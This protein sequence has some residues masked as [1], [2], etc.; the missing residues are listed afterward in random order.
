MRGSLT[1][2][3]VAVAPSNSLARPVQTGGEHLAFRWAGWAAKCG[4]DP[5]FLY[6]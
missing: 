6:A 5:T 3:D 1:A 4:N 2:E